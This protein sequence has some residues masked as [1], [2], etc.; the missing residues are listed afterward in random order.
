[1]VVAK[2]S[3]PRGN[4]GGE[5]RHDGRGRHLCHDPGQGHVGSAG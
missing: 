3:E 4:Q 2:P 5:P 1:M